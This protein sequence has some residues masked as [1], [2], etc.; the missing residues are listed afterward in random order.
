MSDELMSD[1]I[2]IFSDMNMSDS[3][4]TFALDPNVD[5]S[6]SSA[7]AVK[8]KGSQTSKKVGAAKSSVKDSGPSVSIAQKLKLPEDC[9]QV[10]ELSPTPDGNQL[11]VVAA[12]HGEQEKPAAGA[13]LVYTVTLEANTVLVCP[14]NFKI[15]NIQ[16][17]SE[18]PVASC[19]VPLEANKPALACV[20][21]SGGISIYSLAELAVIS[22][23]TRSASDPRITSVTYS[24]SKCKV[25]HNKLVESDAAI[26]AEHLSLDVPNSSSHLNC[27][28]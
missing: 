8:K 1:S 25:V 13:I 24:S 19:F 23:I 7:N 22:T 16:E 26:A 18:L 6:S 11:I 28:K 12:C 9:T 27:S 2:S 20:L 15:R 5:L 21:R 3:S 10:I 4:G 17:E 14:E